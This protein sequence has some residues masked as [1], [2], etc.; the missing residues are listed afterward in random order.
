M[1]EKQ[2]GTTWMKIY[3]VLLIVRIVSLIFSVITVLIAVIDK[4]TE[5]SEL[6]LPIL[7]VLLIEGAYDVFTYVHLSK[8]TQLGYIVNMVYIFLSPFISAFNVILQNVT[9]QGADPAKLMGVIITTIII[10]IAWSLPNYVYFKNRKFMFE[11]QVNNKSGKVNSIN[12]DEAHQTIGGEILTTKNEPFVD[13]SQIE[14]LRTLKELHEEGIL[15]DDEFTEK[16]KQVLG[17]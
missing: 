8:R 10:L 14:A 12:S 17:I 6:A 13:E 16:K 7:I 5:N 15:S 2:L 4:N 3:T 1:E 9:D 11:E